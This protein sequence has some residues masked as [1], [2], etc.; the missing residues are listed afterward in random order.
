MPSFMTRMTGQVLHPERTGMQDPTRRDLARGRALGSGVERV[1]G[2][3]GGHEETIALGPAEADVAADLGDADAADELAL[4][5]PHRHAAVSHVAS[6]VARAPQVAVH[7]GAHP[8]GAALDAVH[9]EVA[10]ELA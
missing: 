8:V 9:H 1:E 6:R 3:A 10:E 7:V 5:R 4:R 2:L